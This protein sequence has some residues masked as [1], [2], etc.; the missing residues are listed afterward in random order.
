MV[1]PL[2]PLGITAGMALLGSQ[3]DKDN[4]LRGALVGGSL[5]FG[6]ATAL[7]PTAAASGV[8]AAAPIAQATPTMAGG[9]GGSLSA[10]PAVM[11]SGGVSLARSPGAMPFVTS[12]LDKTA[13][14]T[15][16]IGT[17]FG[18]AL[19]DPAVIGPVL[20]GALARP[21]RQRP[22]QAPAGSLPQGQFSAPENLFMQLRRRGQRGR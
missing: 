3:L 20:G 8:G 15:P 9:V 14:A 11:Q 2:V 21:P 6:G 16:G 18:N 17:K 5:G 22:G 7:A 19:T 4:P 10:N 13:A 12:S 1:L